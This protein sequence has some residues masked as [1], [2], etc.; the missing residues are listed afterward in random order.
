MRELW[1]SRAIKSFYNFQAIVQKYQHL[2]SQ[3]LSS[4]GVKV[5]TLENFQNPFRES[6]NHL[7]VDNFFFKEPLKL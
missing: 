1:V 4:L 7:E 3:C 2:W 6:D 5:I